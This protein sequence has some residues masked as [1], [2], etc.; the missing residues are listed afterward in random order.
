MDL[1]SRAARN[2][3]CEATE[4]EPSAMPEDGRL[5]LNALAALFVSDTALSARDTW[6]RSVVHCAV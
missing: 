2:E 6:R 4:A 3:R 5:V 1:A